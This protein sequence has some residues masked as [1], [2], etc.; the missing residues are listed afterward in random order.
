MSGYSVEY[1]S[2]GAVKGLVS[3]ESRDYVP[4]GFGWVPEGG[5]LPTPE[6]QPLTSEQMLSSAK[7]EQDRLLTYATL[8]INPLQYAVDIEEAT[9]EDIALLKKWKKY[10]VDLNRIDQQPHY[11][12]EVDWPA[13][14]G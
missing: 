14:P 10:S 6:E 8:R 12:G 1:W 13:S 2:N 5:L 9:A 3:V 4:E 7:A 11:P